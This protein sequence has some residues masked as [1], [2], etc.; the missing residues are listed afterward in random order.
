MDRVAV[1][2]AVG[3]EDAAGPREG[4]DRVAFGGAEEGGAGEPARAT[5]LI[6]FEAARENG[7]GADRVR[8]GARR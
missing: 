6:V 3:E 5:A 1:E 2:G 8:P 7:V 4:E